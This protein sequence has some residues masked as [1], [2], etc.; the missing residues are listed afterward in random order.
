MATAALWRD[1][2]AKLLA[3]ATDAHGKGDHELADMFT[4]LA[5]RY[6]DQAAEE[7]KIEAHTGIAA[8]GSQG[9]VA[10]QQQQPQP[11]APEDKE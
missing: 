4:S 3:R 6:L 2:A 7:E 9:H 5:M 10:Q 11:K 1:Q 8:S